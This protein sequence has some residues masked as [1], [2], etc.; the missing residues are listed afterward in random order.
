MACG[1]ACGKCALFWRQ[2]FANAAAVFMFTYDDNQKA[3]K[4]HCWLAFSTQPKRFFL[5]L[6]VRRAAWQHR[7][8]SKKVGHWRNGVLGGHAPSHFN[9]FLQ[10]MFAR[11]TLQF[12][13]TYICICNR[14]RSVS[15]SDGEIRDR[16][17]IF[18]D[19]T[20]LAFCF[21][22]CLVNIPALEANSWQRR[23]S[24]N[25]GNWVCLLFFFFPFLPF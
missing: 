7:Y 20:D 19:E 10:K 23:A 2:S 22:S 8:Y 1:M 17:M 13:S 24:S 3:T 25:A 16:D 21:L 18:R 5:H 4:A 14:V 9:F 6:L 12:P 15:F 11:L